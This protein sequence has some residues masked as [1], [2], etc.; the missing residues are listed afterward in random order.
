MSITPPPSGTPF[1]KGESWG[2]ANKNFLLK[3]RK[4]ITYKL[5]LL[6]VSTF[7]EGALTPSLV[8]RAGERS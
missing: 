2:G 6:C 7:L 3:N 1:K 8:E 5:T 4:K